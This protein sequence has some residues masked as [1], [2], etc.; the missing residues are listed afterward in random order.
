L[1]VTLTNLK[2]KS[3]IKSNYYNKMLNLVGILMD[4][5]KI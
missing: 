1:V 5:K 4:Q 3:I 2:S